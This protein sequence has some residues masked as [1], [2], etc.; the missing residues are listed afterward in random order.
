MQNE[1][2]RKVHEAGHYAVNKTE[3]KLKQEFF[4]PKLREKIEK[5]IAN[6]V[7]CIL[8][9][10]KRGKQEGYLHP[11]PK[12]SI[13]LHTYH[14]DHLGPLESTHKNYKYILAIIDSFTKFAWLYPTKSTTTKEVIT[15]LEHQK[16]IFGNPLTMITDRGTAF[17]SH[18]FQE[19]CKEE[20]I[21]HIKITTG[22]ARSNGQVERLNSTIISVLSK[23]SA[24]EPAK[25]YRHVP[26][27]Q[28]IIN[29]TN[30]RSI[31]CTPFK[32]MTGV[33][34]RCKTDLKIK[35]MIDEDNQQQFEDLREELRE[36]AKKQIKKVQEENKKSYNLRRRDP[37]KYHI[38]DL[39][40]IKRTQFGPALKLK[41]KYIGPYKVKKIKGQNSYDVEKHGFHEGPIN[42]ST[43]AEY[44]KPW[45][46]HNNA[47]SG[48]DDTQDGRVVGTR[49]YSTDDGRATGGGRH[50]NRDS[51]VEDAAVNA[52]RR[53]KDDNQ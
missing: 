42:T 5:N 21:Q 28:Q 49:H 15:K 45:M 22:L 36:D 47:S 12:E 24:D 19:Y 40:A 1:I 48:T 20:D 14:I 10:R 43:C 52:A 23:L 3:A 2:I 34:M 16:S 25:W 9:N 26:K 41:P 35:K 33:E 8:Y 39:V 29:S 53:A 11:L 51:R 44:M 38:G 32:L 37:Y 6:C 18:E 4:I 46:S 17:T 27:L 30:Q 7:H 13:P 31:N 50:D